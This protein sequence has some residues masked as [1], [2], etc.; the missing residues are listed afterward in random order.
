MQQTCSRPAILLLC[1]AQLPR[2]YLTEKGLLDLCD[3]LLDL[4]LT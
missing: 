1:G 2:A 4:L 3:V